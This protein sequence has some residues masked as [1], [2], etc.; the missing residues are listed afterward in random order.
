MLLLLKG[1]SDS[2]VKITSTLLQY[3]II[4]IISYDN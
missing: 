3:I 2:T 4:K 1:Q